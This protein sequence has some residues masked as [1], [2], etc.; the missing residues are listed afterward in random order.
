[1]A[2]LASNI[3]GTKHPR[4]SARRPGPSASTCVPLTRPPQAGPEERRHERSA[5]GW[6]KSGGA[7]D[8]QEV[9][10]KAGN[11]DKDQHGFPRVVRTG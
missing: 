11:E 4:P 1:M 7:S 6:V 2:V 5:D 9:A 8:R 10:T 3:R